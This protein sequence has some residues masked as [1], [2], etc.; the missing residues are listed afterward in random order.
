MIPTYTFK[1]HKIFSNFINPKKL[2]NCIDFKMELAT[3]YRIYSGYQ[4]S[5]YFLSEEKGTGIRWY[6]RN[7]LSK[8]FK[9]NVQY[10]Y[11]IRKKTWKSTPS[12]Y[13]STNEIASKPRIYLIGPSNICPYSREQKHVLL[14]RKSE[15]W[16][17]QVSITNMPH[18]F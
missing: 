5:F 6:V 14:F 3:L 17:F 13:L 12:W 4:I 9:I 1:I 16:L 15:I 10:C 2:R 18:L 7:L 8:S 11:V